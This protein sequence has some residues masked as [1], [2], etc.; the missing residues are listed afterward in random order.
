[1]KSTVSGLYR[2]TACLLCVVMI[3]G[4]LPV[5]ALASQPDVTL[6]LAELGDCVPLNNR[7]V[8]EF[9][10]D[11]YVNVAKY[12]TAGF[13][14][15]PLPVKLTWKTETADASLAVDGYTIRVS[16]NADLSEARV[17][18]AD[19]TSVDVW[20]L[21]IG[22][23][24]YWNV[25]AH[26]RKGDVVSRTAAFRTDGSSPRT[27]FVDKVD[28]ARDLGGWRT[29]D[30]GVIRQGLMYRMARLNSN[31][32][33]GTS[34]VLISEAG[35]LT[36]RSD[37][38]IR[39]EI[40]LRE[41]TNNENGGLTSS[42]LGEGVRYVSAPLLTNRQFETTAQNKESLRYLFEE[43]FT[44][45]DNYPL[46]FHCS[47]GTDR[48][49]A[50]AYFL[51]AL[52]GVSETDLV[53]DYLLSDLGQNQLRT[54]SN[55]SAWYTLKVNA[56]EGATLSEKVFGYLT[57]EI[58]VSAAAL[59]KIVS[60]LKEPAPAQPGAQAV[61]TASEFMAMDPDGHYVLTADLTLP[62]SYAA[63][64]RGTLDGNG[65]RLTLDG[66]P[67][68][69]ELDGS[70]KDLVLD[71]T[72][73]TAGLCTLTH[74][75]T[76][77]NVR[78]FVNVTADTG[79]AAGLAATVAG[80]ATFVDCVNY[81]RIS[82][83]GSA[84]GIV[85]EAVCSVAMTRCDNYGAITV[86]GRDFV[87]A[88]GLIGLAESGLS[89]ES[90]NNYAPITGKG[91]YTAGVAACL[92]TGNCMYSLSACGNFGAVSSTGRYA[93]GITA[94][95]AGS[96][97][98]GTTL[99]AQAH[100]VQ[101]FNRGSVT[102]TVPSGRAAG[103]IACVSGLRAL[104]ARCY[105]AADVTASGSDSYAAQLF[106]A[107][108]ALN[109]NFL[110]ENYAAEG[111]AV[112]YYIVT[113]GTPAAGAAQT[114]R[115]T[116]LRSVRSFTAAELTSG[117][118]T[119]PAT[120]ALNKY[121]DVYVD[122]PDGPVTAAV[123]RYAGMNVVGGLFVVF[124]GD[125]SCEGLYTGF[126]RAP[127]GIMYL[128]NGRPA[129]GWQEINGDTYWL[130]PDTGYAAVGVVN[131]DGKSYLF[132]EDGRLQSSFDGLTLDADGELRYYVNGKPIHAGLVKEGDDYF[133]ITHHLTAVRGA[134][135]Y[136]Q[137][138]YANGLLQP[139]L[140]EFDA[141]GRMIIKNGL[142]R[143][144]DGEIRFYE[145][146]RPQY[147]GLI[148]TEAGDY[149]Y[150]TNKKVAVRGESHYIL[151]E[152]TNGLLAPGRYEFDE[153]GKLI[154]KNGLVLDAD[155]ELRYYVMSQPQYTGLIRTED[156]EFYY[157]C[158]YKTAVRG[159][160]HLVLDAFANGLLPQG[161]YDFD[162]SG[163]LYFREGLCLDEDGELR[164]YE[165]S[166]AQYAG[167]ICVDGHLY[168]ITNKKVAVR[169]DVH[170][171]FAERANGLAAAGVYAFDA[172]GHMVGAAG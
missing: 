155:G 113:N 26:T 1:M 123:R 20:N 80:D 163:R 27:L 87:C 138:A 37:L 32:T 141:E 83:S 143:D 22:T 5:I 59:D 127:H 9:M 166:V 102:T 142:W 4:A 30:G 71:G 88:A 25:T 49:G 8:T 99:D 167:L 11:S 106:F 98:T 48:T 63:S 39:T 33:T 92:P 50:V 120:A 107:N 103:I 15:K 35:I 161:W 153:D 90:S 129:A 112:P 78:S 139:G 101:C 21:K 46:F 66:F 169:S 111:G 109:T 53:R 93:A 114:G 125:G 136:V 104:V 97:L 152:Y 12:R 151:P 164:F 44:D 74:G 13:S 51:G 110:I 82:N 77:K 96:V 100:F 72:S 89:I 168:Y 85:G 29:L 150:I 119:D 159:E 124:S 58:G 10:A 34:N 69:A 79:A 52:C 126:F 75:M 135:H 67:V 145:M 23:T 18:D 45:E 146:S 147:K 128:Q 154:V 148:R 62:A 61:S 70:V 137:E 115:L 118:L 73:V 121:D 54:V 94:Y 36:M 122:A 7:F 14:T 60:I 171:I 47:I 65:H 64:F 16:E 41:V 134:S 84:A 133:Y 165:H 55:I 132:D 6:T 38:G 140:Y 95:A 108:S 24:Y 28:N 19:K 158:K 116:S 172:Q 130:D 86:S 57:R 42:P 157:I 3:L 81:G 43:V 162:E 56:Q 40:D 149:Y 131:I 144:A 17:Y 31:V 170:R 117:F 76:A 105:N 160:R 2:L 68:F 91:N 156:G